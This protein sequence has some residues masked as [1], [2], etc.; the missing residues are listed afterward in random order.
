MARKWKAELLSRERETEK[1]AE[2]GDSAS[3][4]GG[5]RSRGERYFL[6]L[7]RFL[8]CVKAIFRAVYD[9][10]IAVLHY[11]NLHA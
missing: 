8:P 1:K 9:L 6:E 10:K 11:A 4:H 3:Y 5:E 2:V 7:N